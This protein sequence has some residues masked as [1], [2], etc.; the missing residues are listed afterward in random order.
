MLS[1]WRSLEELDRTLTVLEEKLV[2]R[3]LTRPQEDKLVPLREQAARELAPYRGKM[4]AVQIKQVQ[5]QFLQKRLLEAQA[6]AAESLLYEPRMRLQIEKVVYGGAGLARTR[7]GAGCWQGGLCALHA[8]GRECRSDSSTADK[9]GYGEASLVQVIEASPDRVAARCGHF[10]EC[11]GC[12]LQHATYR[13]Q[14]QMK[15]RYSARDAAAR[16]A[17]CRARGAGA[18]RRAVGLSESDKAARG[19]G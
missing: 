18:C 11:G 9:S 13:A 19:S 17:G 7:D 8:A 4:Q 15:T 14:V 10:G 3:S 12:Q 5:Q 16:G 6:A 1:R 2:R